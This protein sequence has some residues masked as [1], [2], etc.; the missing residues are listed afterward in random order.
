M[1]PIEIPLDS[2]ALRANLPGTTQ[3]VV[4]PE[5]YRPL[6][7]AVEGYQ[8][9]KT[10]L[11]ETLA[12]YFHEHRNVDL[13][14]AA[15]GRLAPTHPDLRLLIAG[16]TEPPAPDFARQ[17]RQPAQ[18]AQGWLSMK[19]GCQARSR[20]RIGPNSAGTAISLRLWAAKRF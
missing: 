2:D 4:I 5:R 13:L 19:K 1:D 14:V 6:I 11:A 12:E 7:K 10:P 15:F 20:S 18:E 16:P 3:P 8:G 17:V 9:V